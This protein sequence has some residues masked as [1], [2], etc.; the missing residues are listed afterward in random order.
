MELTKEILEKR[1]QA[2]KAQKEQFAAQANAC[3]GGILTVRGL[4]TE[5]ETEEPVKEEEPVEEESVEEE[6]DGESEEEEDDG[7]QV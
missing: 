1:L 6:L 3:E 5:L 4:I 7:E 2:L